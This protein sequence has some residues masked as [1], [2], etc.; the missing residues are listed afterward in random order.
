MALQEDEG[1]QTKSK[2]E[3]P[4]KR[5]LIQPRRGRQNG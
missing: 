5:V 3:G 2:G 1:I 4:L